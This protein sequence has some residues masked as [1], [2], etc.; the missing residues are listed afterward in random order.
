MRRIS[1]A[2]SDVA[3]T[4]ERIADLV[5]EYANLLG[6]AR[7]TDTVTL[8][9]AEDGFASEASLLLGPASQIAVTANDYL[10]LERVRLPGVDDVVQDLQARI[11]RLTG[12]GRRDIVPED[13]EDA[14][15]VDAETAFLDFDLFQAPPRDDEPRG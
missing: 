8:P 15:A 2:G 3:V 13:S 10:H 7:T 9:V 6:R 1:M 12:S 4:D 11:A 5:L 14:S